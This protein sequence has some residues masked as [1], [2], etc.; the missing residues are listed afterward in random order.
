VTAAPLVSVVVPCFNYGHLLRESLDSVL[1]QS[2]QDWEC[3]VV[4]DGSTD[5]TSAVAGS[6]AAQ[7]ARFVCLRQENRGL[8][9]ARNAGLRKARGELVQLLDADDLLEAEKLKEHAHFL[10]RHP[11]FDLVYGAMRYFTGQGP[12]RRRSLGRHGANQEWMTLWPDTSQDMLLALVQGNQFPVSAALFRKSL[13][14]EMGYFD[15]ALASH[16]DWEFWLRCALA[17]KRFCGRDA[18][19][20]RTLIREHGQSLTRR[21]ITMAE[22]RLEV[23]RRIDKIAA[24]EAL[25]AVNRECASYDECEL[26]GAHLAAGH[27]R[28]GTRWLRKGFAEAPRKRLAMRAFL[29]QVAPGWLLQSWRQLRRIASGGAAA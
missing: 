19:A 17:G 9:A 27:W 15:E 21:A 29:A 26:G 3:I 6:Y 4:D 1:G 22:T 7:D 13:P 25:R 2:L 14:A 11:E 18:P 5:D 10:T 23:R 8:S 28:A 24:A 20:T 12:E 16:E